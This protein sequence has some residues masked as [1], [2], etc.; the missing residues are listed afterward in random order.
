[1]TVLEL[2]EEI[3]DI[4]DTAP[5][6]P[7]TGKIMVDANELLEIVREIRLSLPDDVQQAKWVKDEKERILTEAKGEYEKIIVEAK[8]Q[9]DYLVETD[10]IT[11]RAQKMAEGIQKD[12][13]DYAKVLKMRTY[14]YVDK[15]LYD[16]Q[17]RM[18][19]L[20]M[21]YFGEMYTSLEK[22]FQEIGGVLQSNRDEIKEMAYRTQNG[23]DEVVMR[24]EE[25]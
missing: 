10:D 6:L 23:Q 9:A 18:D 24:S 19:E 4:V 13:E 12:A 14:D 11:L 5:G 20:N 2:L 8:K 17:A 3:E 16:M 7:L 21:K 1:M 25:E 22:S 15:M